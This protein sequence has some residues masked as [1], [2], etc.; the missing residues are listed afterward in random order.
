LNLYLF[1]RNIPDGKFDRV[2]THFGTHV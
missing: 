1:R 2:S